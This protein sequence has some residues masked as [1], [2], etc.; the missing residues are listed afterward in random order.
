[1][2]SRVDIINLREKITPFKCK[3]GPR[4]SL[5]VIFVQ[6]CG[7]DIDSGFN[8]APIKQILSHIFVK[9]YFLFFLIYTCFDF[10][11]FFDIKRQHVDIRYG[12]VR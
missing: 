2:R 4:S 5:L 11:F 8:G 3:D 7:S 1:M 6:S 12:Y 9:F 10:F